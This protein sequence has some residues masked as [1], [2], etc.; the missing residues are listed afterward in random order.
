[1]ATIQLIDKDNREMLGSDGV[2]YID[3]RYS[4]DSIKWCVRSRN[5]RYSK[6]FPHKIATAFIYKN[7][8]I[9]L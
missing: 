9:S 4:I 2:M 3:G 7:K 1:M 6:N 5:S 8:R